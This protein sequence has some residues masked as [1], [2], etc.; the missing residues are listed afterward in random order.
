LSAGAGQHAFVMF[1]APILASFVVH[2]FRVREAGH[3]CD[4]RPA[5]ETR[6]DQRLATVVAK[7]V[8]GYSSLIQS[9]D[10]EVLSA[11][12]AIQEASQKLN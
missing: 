11:L 2:H 5:P 3:P 10:G 9:D 8:V 7:D 4:A 1:I 6:L 12:T